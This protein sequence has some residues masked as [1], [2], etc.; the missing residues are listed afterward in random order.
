MVLVAA[1][2]AEAGFTA[3]GNNLVIA[4]IA[5]VKRKAVFNFAATYNL[6]NFVINNG[7]NGNNFNKV[8]PNV[9]K[10]FL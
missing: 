5:F 1:T 4:A 6:A 9:S 3:E 7:T 2:V 10:N 8:I